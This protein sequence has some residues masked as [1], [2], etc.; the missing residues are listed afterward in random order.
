[1]LSKR[2]ENP[3]VFKCF[4]VFKSPRRTT[5]QNPSTGVSVSSPLSSRPYWKVIFWHSA[6]SL[7]CIV[8]ETR[9]YR[10]M[11]QSATSVS[12][13]VRTISRWLLPLFGKL[14]FFV[15]LIVRYFQMLL[16]DLRNTAQ[17]TK[18]T[19]ARA[20]PPISSRSRSLL[21]SLAYSP[22][23]QMNEIAA[24]EK[25]HPKTDSKMLPRNPLLSGRIIAVD[26]P[27]RP[28]DCPQ[29]RLPLRSC[30]AKKL[31]RPP[32]DFFRQSTI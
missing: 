5:D 27:F 29:F 4:H 12:L 22:P 31:V 2:F 28:H 19:A 7:R 18:K 10:K 16:S 17:H 3:L 6:V 13:P 25:K 20:K 8:S 1:M 11:R 14:E 21:V 23:P 15:G 30:P 32:L 26:T 24:V 9:D